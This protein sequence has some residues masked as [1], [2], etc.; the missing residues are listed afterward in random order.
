MAS[1]MSAGLMVMSVRAMVGGGMLVS[2]L[3]RTWPR[4]KVVYSIAARVGLLWVSAQRPG[5]C[6]SQR[7]RSRSCPEAKLASDVVGREH[8]RVLG[9]EV[10]VPRMISPCLCRNVGG[11]G[12]RCHVLGAVVASWWRA[13]RRS[14]VWGRRG[15]GLPSA[16]AS[17][18]VGFRHGASRLASLA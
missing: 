4:P 14:R 5:K 1:R 12:K 11:G 15:R 7:R 9:P 8:C 10:E 6:L 17:V 16:W 13:R 18:R 3:C 2:E